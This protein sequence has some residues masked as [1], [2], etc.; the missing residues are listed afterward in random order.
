MASVLVVDDTAVN[1][2]LIATVLSFA[3]HRVIEAADGATA[4]ELIRRERPDLVITDLLMPVM[5]GYKLAREIRADPELA[6][7]PIVFYTANYLE[8]EIRPFAIATGVGHI[9][10][11]P[12]DPERLIE[13]V[14]RAL[15]EEPIGDLPFPD[16]DLDREHLRIVNLK[17]LQRVDELERMRAELRRR[18]ER[19]PTEAR[20]RSAFD[21][22]RTGLCLGD[23]DGSVVE[24]NRAFLDVFGCSRAKLTTAG[25]YGLLERSDLDELLVQFRSLSIGAISEFDTSVIGRS[26]GEHRVALRLSLGL[27]ARES[28]SAGDGEP[29][30]GEPGEEVREPL[31]PGVADLPFQVVVQ[32][33]AMPPDDPA[34]VADGTSFAS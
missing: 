16:E 18:D 27:M 22:T 33:E 6:S 1:R 32:L 20:F 26:D 7:L 19:E 12:V 34:E 15:T 8:Q 21:A 30:D 29:G 11:K 31:I 3:G 10:V 24:V 25:W 9:L 13:V 17:L 23:P 5:D 14:E 4:M 28:D 2:N